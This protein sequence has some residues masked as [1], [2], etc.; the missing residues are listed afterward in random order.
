[1]SRS[2][3]MLRVL[4]SDRNAFYRDVVREHLSIGR[5]GEIYVAE[6]PLET[7]SCLLTKP[8]DLLVA[9]WESLTCNDG[10]LLELLVRRARTTRRAMP[11]LALMAKPTHADVMRAANNA[12]DLVL[13]KPFSPKMLQ[14]RVEWLLG[15]AEELTEIMETQQMSI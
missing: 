7:V 8:F 2:N 6:S 14:Q 9:D 15:R 12:V 5:L 1:M 13:R 4:I 10:A 3:T 11:V